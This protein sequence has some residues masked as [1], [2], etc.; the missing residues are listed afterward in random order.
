M[1]P[2]LEKVA[3]KLEG[4]MAIGKI[5]CTVHKSL[6]NEYKVR[7]YPTI[8]YSIDGTLEQYPGGRD[9]NS[10]VAFATK[11]SADPVIFVSSKE[12]ALEFTKTKTE[13]GVAFLG[14][15]PKNDE[16]T[17]E[18]YK[19]F[20]QVARK[21]Q[22]SGYFLW[23]K[24]SQEAIQ[25]VNRIEAGSKPRDWDQKEMTVESFSSW[26]QEH[27]VPLISVL[28]SHNFYKISRNGR[29]L[30]VSI[31]DMANEAQVNALRE[32]MKDFIS[33]AGRKSA[34]R[35]YFTMMDGKKWSRFLEQFRVETQH[36]P[37][38]IVIDVPTKE[39]YQN[40]TYDN[41]FDFMEAVEDGTL[42]KSIASPPAAKGFLA[43]IE[44]AFLD[45]F[46]YSLLVP[47]SAVFLIVFLLVPGPD[48]M[49]PKYIPEDAE[50][51]IDDDDVRD[52]DKASA[53]DT[54]GNDAKE[55]KKDK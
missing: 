48:D 13:E 9:E 42:E 11:M 26:V 52:D 47:I 43:K 17:S 5:D 55:S 39:F 41:I 18:L 23:L 1:A 3:P 27:N 53:E 30:V 6:C 51:E 20:S 40:E 10:I 19:I 14:Y 38:T 46:P 28:D 33:R 45:N 25:Y 31:V 32:H 24:E 22:A 7:G 36:I 34:D 8:K 50:G 35:Y 16:E 2:V 49:R 29:P 15:D 37:Q 4:K 21:K 44:R 54:N 12:E